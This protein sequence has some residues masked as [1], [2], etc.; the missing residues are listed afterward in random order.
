MTETASRLAVAA[1]ALL[2]FVATSC[3]APITCPPRHFAR[4]ET[5]CPPCVDGGDCPCSVGWVCREDPE[6]GEERTRRAREEALA[7]ARATPREAPIST[8]VQPAPSAQPSAPSE[9]PRPHAV[10]EGV[11]AVCGEPCANGGTRRIEVQCVEGERIRV[12]MMLRC[13]EVLRSEARCAVPWHITSVCDPPPPP[14]RPRP[15]CRARTGT[16]CLEDGTVVVPCGAGP[17]RPGCHGGAC[18]S[19]GFCNGCR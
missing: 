4:E 17:A 1:A 18:G 12:H 19:G 10:P 16:C 5:M 9:P 7:R 13:P 3:G 14:P 11:P 8:G 6:V 15:P 2:L